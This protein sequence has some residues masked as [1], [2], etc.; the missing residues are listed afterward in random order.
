V[1]NGNRDA[2]ANATEQIKHSKTIA[3]QL[4]ITGT[5][6]RGIRVQSTRAQRQG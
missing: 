5:T 4:R 2:D 1:L 6:Q 3:F